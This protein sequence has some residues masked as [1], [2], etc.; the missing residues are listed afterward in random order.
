M[1]MP[2]TP[3]WPSD[4]VLR[5]QNKVILAERLRWPEGALQACQEL[6]QRH[7]GWHVTWLNEN[8][9]AGFER[10]AG[11]HARFDGGRHKVG[12]YAATTEKL[13]PEMD[14]PEHDYALK[15]C[16]WC[17]AYPNGKTVRL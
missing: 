6:E 16:A 2:P 9:R 8:T 4:R 3:R 12:I 1:P 14:V 15:G 5:S 10:P 13:E 11:F 7:P 17:Y